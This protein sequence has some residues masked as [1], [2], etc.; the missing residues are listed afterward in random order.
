MWGS[1]G[2]TSL[3]KAV[4]ILR[5]RPAVPEILIPT[6]AVAWDALSFHDQMVVWKLIGAGVPGR[7]SELI[8]AGRACGLM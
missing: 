8:V 3:A 6:E 7:I 4:W 1:L 5:N 2:K